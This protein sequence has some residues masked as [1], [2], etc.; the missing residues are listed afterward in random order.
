MKKT[1]I[2]AAVLLAVLAAISLCSC[3][4][5][6]DEGNNN[7]VRGGDINVTVEISSDEYG[8]LVEGSVGVHDG[9]TVLDAITA[10]CAAEGIEC[11][12]NDELTSVVALGEYT[13]VE[14]NKLSYYWSYTLNGKEPRGRASENTVADGDV[15]VYNYTFIPTGDYVTVRFEAEGKVIVN[16]TTVVY[17]EGDTVLDAA[18]EALKRSGIDYGAS[19]DNTA[20]QYVDDYLAK[21]TPIYDETW[22]AEVNGDAVADPSETALSNGAEIVFTF[23]RVEKEVTDTQA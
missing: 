7:I 12:Y 21:I 1:K 6:T 23:N 22:D 15:V 13:E 9:A 14:R 19:D 4:G 8:V 11:T 18:L 20:I 2:F 17:D 10:Y 5:E 3:G 16:D